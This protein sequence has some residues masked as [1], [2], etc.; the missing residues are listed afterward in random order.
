MIGPVNAPLV[1]V[2]IFSAC[3]WVGSM[4]S[5]AV[6]ANAARKVLDGSSQV[7]FFRAVGQRYA[8]VGTASLLV[9][10]GAGLW[11]AWPPRTWSETFDAAVGLACLLVVATA[12]GMAQAR[13]MTRMRRRSIA[14]P[15]DIAAAAAVR[16]GRRLAAMLRGLMGAVTS[17]IVVLAAQMVSH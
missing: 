7:R 2:E 11:L 14:A 9:A 1:A 5:L 13:A 17:A 10:I 12:A 16:R 6:V 4:V 15:D 3:V 8:V